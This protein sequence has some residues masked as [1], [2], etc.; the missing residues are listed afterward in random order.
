CSA[1]REAGPGRAGRPRRRA[2]RLA[3]GVPDPGRGAAGGRAGALETPRA[4]ARPSRRIRARP[5]PLSAVRGAAP[6]LATG[7]DRGGDLRARP[8]ARNLAA[9]AR[10]L[11]RGAVAPLRHHAVARHL[12]ERADLG[13]SWHDAGGERSLPVDPAPQLP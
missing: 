4:R 13:S 12:L 6:A 5:P 2:A 10:D 11:P 3:P 1:S 9:G 7:T 8:P